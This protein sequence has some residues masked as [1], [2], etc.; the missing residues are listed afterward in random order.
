MYADINQLHLNVWPGPR[1]RGKLTKGVRTAYHYITEAT[2]CCGER[3]IG[4][5]PLMHTYW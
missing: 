1:V 2:V 4:D 3:F 5:R